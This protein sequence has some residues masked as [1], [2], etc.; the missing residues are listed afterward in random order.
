MAKRKYAVVAWLP[1][2]VIENAKET[3]TG[4]TEAEAAR[5]LDAEE[6]RI[7]DAMVAAGW[8]AIENALGKREAARF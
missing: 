2:D 8:S 6:M 3:G 1:E 4:M 5:L 7:I